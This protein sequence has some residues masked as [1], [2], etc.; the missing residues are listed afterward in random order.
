MTPTE[1]RSG[2]EGPRLA[3]WRVFLVAHARTVEAVERE[4]ARVD[5]LPLSW[6]QVLIALDEA[7][8]RRLRMHELATAVGLSPSGLSRLVDRLEARGFLERQPCSEDRRCQFAALTEAGLNAL[9]K[10]WSSYAAGIVRHFGG[11]LSDAE[12]ET[13]RGLLDRLVECRPGGEP[14]A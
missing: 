11:R 9:E 1:L 4:L 5:T 14:A 8:G 7:P 13:L 2:L 12:L 10:A 6:Y 3:A